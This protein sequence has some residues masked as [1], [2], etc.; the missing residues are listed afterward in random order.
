MRSLA[1]QGR[2]TEALR[3]YQA[4]RRFLADEVGVEPSDALR[5]LDRRISAGW[6]DQVPASPVEVVA[7]PGGPPT[8]LPA[9]P[10]NFVGHA[11]ELRSS[12]FRSRPISWSRS[13]APVGWARHA[14]PSKLRARPTGRSTERG[15][16]SSGHS[17][18]ALA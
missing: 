8:N 2:H 9:L 4:Y 15:W 18:T 16:S 5:Q 3:E 10:S 17:A 1:A 6:R 12:A 7:A 13:S 14:W 11:S